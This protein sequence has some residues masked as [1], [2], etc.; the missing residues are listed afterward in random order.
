MQLNREIEHNR[1]TARQTDKQMKTFCDLCV[2]CADSRKLKAPSITG[3]ETRGVRYIK[4]I[5][6]RLMKR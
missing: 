3:D 2:G 6:R 5:K 1:H 4:T